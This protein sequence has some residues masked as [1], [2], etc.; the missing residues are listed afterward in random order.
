MNEVQETIG[1]KHSRPRAWGRGCLG[2][3]LRSSRLKVVMKRV[4][5]NEVGGIKTSFPMQGGWVHRFHKLQLKITHVTTKDPT[6]H[7]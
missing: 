2:V 1:E 7:N 5:Q 4:V 3:I 6:S